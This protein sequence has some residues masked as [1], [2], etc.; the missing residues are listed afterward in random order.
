VFWIGDVISDVSNDLPRLIEEAVR[1]SRVA[2]PG[3]H[4][5]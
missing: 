2:L 1:M 4:L 5:T 3:L